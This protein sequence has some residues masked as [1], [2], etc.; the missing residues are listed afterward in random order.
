MPNAEYQQ[1]IDAVNQTRQQG[2]L[3][4]VGFRCEQGQL[5]FQL[6]D[7]WYGCHDEV[8]LDTLERYP[9]WERNGA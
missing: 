3:P 6:G 2:K 5:Q 7:T 8:A 1:R 9:C 4:P